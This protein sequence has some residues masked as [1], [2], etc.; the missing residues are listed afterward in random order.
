MKLRNVVNLV[1]AILML[2]TVAMSGISAQATSITNIKLKK[3][4]AIDKALI[5]KDTE[6]FSKPQSVLLAPIF[7]SAD[8]KV[9]SEDWYR[10]LFYYLSS[11]RF[12]FKDIPAHYV[13]SEDGVIYEGIDGGIERNLLVKDGPEKPILILYL[14]NRDDRDFSV[15]ARNALSAF[16]LNLANENKIKQD[17]FQIANLKMVINHSTKTVNLQSS[18]IFGSWKVTF[19]DF[20]DNIAAHYDPT[21]RQYDVAVTSYTNPTSKVKIGQEVVLKIKLKNNSRFSI[22]SDDDSELVL[23]REGNKDSSYFLNNVWLSKS[24]VG[25]LPSGTIMRPGE[26]REFD[27]KVKA[28][29]VFGQ[30]TENFTI[31]N[32][33]GQD[34][35][36]TKIAITLDVDRGDLK[37]LQIQ[38]TEGG[39][40]NVRAAASTSSSSIGKAS[41]GDRY[42]WTEISNNG[43]YKINFGGSDGWVLGKYVKVI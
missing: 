5:V 24:Q 17:H 28:P 20:K 29:F 23:T 14:A 12:N 18:E 9:K 25:L 36:N 10:A 35:A 15:N 13:V 2:A 26:E 6:N 22:Y 4:I 8:V 38:G 40:V 7:L 31:K 21:P 11:D 30:V 32:G 16:L 42:T 33:Y 34:L 41:E 1:M 27:F 19:N 39:I 37:V 43:W 3:D